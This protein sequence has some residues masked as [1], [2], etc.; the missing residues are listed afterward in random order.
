VHNSDHY[1]R[2]FDTINMKYCIPGLSEGLQQS[3]VAECRWA[4]EKLE[5]PAEAFQQN[6][7]HT[8]VYVEDC[9][10]L[11]KRIKKVIIW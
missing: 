7:E 9:I 8:T 5:T 4:V 2:E 6:H 10:T 11:L 1:F 3:G